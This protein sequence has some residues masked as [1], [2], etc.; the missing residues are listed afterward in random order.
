MP[1]NRPPAV[2]QLFEI[3]TRLTWS[4]RGTIFLFGFLG[5][6][7][8][9]SLV[10]FMHRVE[11]QTLFSELSPEDANTIVSRLR[12]EKKDFTARET[13]EGTIIKVAGTRDE[14]STMQIDY[15]GAG[16][17]GSGRVGF[18]IFDKSQFG[19]TDFTEKVN[20]QRALQGSLSRTIES[21]DEI[22]QATVH[23]SLAKDSVYNQEKEEATA[24]VVIKLKKGS[25]L[26]KLKIA[27]IKAI[28]KGA[29]E[30]LSARNI[31]IVDSEANLLTPMVESG[32]AEQ[33]VMESSYREQQE[34]EISSKVVSILEP[35]VGNDKVRVSTSIDMDFN[36]TE[37]MEEQYNPNAQAVLSQQKSEERAGPSNSTITSGIPGTESNLTPPSMSNSSMMERIRQSEATNYEVSKLIR[38]TVQP[39]GTIRRISV[40]VILD[41]KTIYNQKEDGSV[42]STQ[43]PISQQV[44]DSCRNA[45]TAAIGY[46]ELRGDVVT[47]ENVPFY[48]EIKPVETLPEEPFYVEWKVYL[49]PGMKYLAFIVLFLMVYL[50]FLRPI[51]RRVSHALS[52]AALGTGEATEA[53]LHA[54][55][56]AAALPEGERAGEIEAPPSRGSDTSLPPRSSQYPDEYLSLEASDEQIE[57]EL[58]KEANMIDLGNRKYSAMKNKLI[59]K[60]KKDPEMIS[61]LIRSV[62]RE[63]I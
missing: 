46:N 52:M 44:L 6:A 43:E 49:I 23:L 62:L 25:E 45:V 51:R 54:R 18:D 14:I 30:G 59:E 9:G 61:Q 4:Q 20:L 17:A 40:A 58:M 33:N 41:H 24:S 19:M 38:H 12:D 53:Q 11:Y 1:A 10:F 37:Q 36:T 28:I 56:E 5:L 32:D 8:I 39:K 31:S 60:A 26:S 16:L 48:T 13:D 22:I 15:K 27:G 47:I 2:N 63:G 55:N 3:W 29:V 57:R 7:L 35:M 34:K 42:S 50:I 21:L